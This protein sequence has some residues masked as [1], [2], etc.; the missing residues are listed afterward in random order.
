M[1]INL[2]EIYTMCIGVTIICNH[3]TYSYLFD[4]YKCICDTTERNK[5]H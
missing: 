5:C 2:R 1:F 4:R 3:N